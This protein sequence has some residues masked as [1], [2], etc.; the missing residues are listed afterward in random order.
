LV[1]GIEGFVAFAH[2]DRK[3]HAVGRSDV[4][5][6][7]IGQDEFVARLGIGKTHA[8]RIARITRIGDAPH[9]TV[10]LELR[11]GERKQRCEMF[12]RQAANAKMHGRSSVVVTEDTWRRRARNPTRF[13]RRSCR[14]LKAA[15]ARRRD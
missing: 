5:M 1:D 12:G 2:K 7:V 13:L 8:A 9:C 6:L 11:I 15:A 4:M 3:T 14:G 10:L